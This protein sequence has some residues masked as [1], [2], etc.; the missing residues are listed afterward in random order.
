MRTAHGPNNSRYEE[1]SGTIAMVMD[2]ALLGE[3]SP[4]G[5]SLGCTAGMRLI[6]IDRK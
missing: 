2:S 3:L 6:A 4:P 1:T 5:Q